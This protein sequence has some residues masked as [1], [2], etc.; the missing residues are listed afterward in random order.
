MEVLGID[1]GS[2]GIKGAIVDT[3]KGEIISD[4]KSTDKIKDTRPHKLISQL[5]KVV[6]KFDW[7]GPIGCAFP[8]ATTRGR[9]LAT[10]RIHEAWIDA[11]AEQLFSE[12]TG[13]KVSVIN[14]T[15][16][17]G[18]AEMSFGVGKGH[19]GTVIVLAVGTGIGSSLFVNKTLVPNTE[20]GQLEIKGI[21]VEERASNRARKEEGIQKKTWAKRLQFVLEHY[22]RV[23]HP[24]LFIL[25]GQLSKKANK[26]FPYI[27]INTKFK[28]AE[29][30][31]EASIVG[32][33]LYAA[34]KHKA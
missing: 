29:F 8:A 17:T 18:L 14:D 23:F 34:S 32:A 13:C 27:K 10:D 19:T 12:I 26:T 24:D 16:A 7:K 31:N 28:A 15:D 11:D 22:E 3:E 20:L 1:I 21:T 4:K 33:A 5:H 2:Y 9:I 30:Q 25:G 6:K